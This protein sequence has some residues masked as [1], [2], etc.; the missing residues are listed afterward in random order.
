MA[1][2]EFH[3]LNSSG[4]EARIR[5]ACLLIEQLYQ[6]QK[7]VFV[8]VDSDSTATKIDELLWI[9]RDQAFIPHELC[10]AQSPSD[11]R[12]KVLIG[13]DNPPIDFQTSI[14]HLGNDALP[15]FHN[16]S[17]IIE[18]VDADPVHKQQARERYKQYRDQGHQLDTI[19]H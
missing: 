13:L 5:H 3:I 9:F 8:L 19:N 4:D 15:A 17:L 10:T 7:T 6:Q 12:I 18:I 14:I 1:R 2:I 11:D 16:T